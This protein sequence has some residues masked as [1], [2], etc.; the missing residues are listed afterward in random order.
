M[1]NRGFYIDTF[2]LICALMICIALN[3]CNGKKHADSQNVYNLIIIDESGSMLRIEKE[4]V[5]GLNDTFQTIAAA[6]K[7]HTQQRHFVSLVT[8]NGSRI[9]TVYDRKPVEEL[10][11]KWNDYHPDDMTPLFDAM[12]CSIDSL[13]KHVKEGDIVLVTIITDGQENASKT[14][15]GKQI[16]EMV[17]EL[18]SKGWVF[19][20]IGTN[21]DV[22][23]VAEEIGVRNSMGYRYSS[24]GTRDMWERERKSRQRFYGRAAYG[25]YA[26]T[27]NDSDYF[28]KE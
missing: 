11:K 12:G 13:K 28:V 8:F 14:Y 5:N 18:K 25:G 21:Q 7:E 23:A 10:N 9:N 17:S 16:K 26:A 20:Y 1:K 6:Q 27:K 15:S 2:K 3:A 22:D 24:E 4:A 19:A